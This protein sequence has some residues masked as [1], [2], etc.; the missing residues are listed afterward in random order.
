MYYVPSLV[1]LALYTIAINP[2][3]HSRFKKK[4]SFSFLKVS[5]PETQ[6][7]ISLSHHWYMAELV[8]GLM[9]L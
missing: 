8:L 7:V 6:S 5:T 3:Y 4:I 1:S 2:H 9:S